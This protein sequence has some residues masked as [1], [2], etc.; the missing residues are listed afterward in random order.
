MEIRITCLVNVMRRQ[1]ASTNTVASP[2]KTQC[3][4]Y[5]ACEC[6]SSTDSTD[7]SQ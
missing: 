5:G 1:H 7:I 2:L 3:N 4:T 6:M